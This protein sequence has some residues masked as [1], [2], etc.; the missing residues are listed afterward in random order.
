[1]NQNNTPIRIKWKRTNTNDPI[2]LCFQVLR[3]QCV[4]FYVSRWISVTVVLESFGRRRRRSGWESLVRSRSQHNTHWS[5]PL[6]PVSS[7]ARASRS[8]QEPNA[9]DTRRE[10][11]RERLRPTIY[12]AARLT[13]A[14]SLGGRPPACVIV[15]GGRR[16]C[17][18][19]ERNNKANVGERGVICTHV[20]PRLCSYGRHCDIVT[21]SHSL[22]DAH[23]PHAYILLPAKWVFN[24]IN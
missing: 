21:H 18:R 24:F 12:L 19:P 13:R 3:E 8:T 14:R 6:R 5:I 15:C 11:E 4:F 1:M 23:R 2:Y 9:P 7:L 10:R 16:R 22:A 17:A 20:L